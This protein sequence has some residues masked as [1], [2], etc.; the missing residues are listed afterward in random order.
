[1]RAGDSHIVAM[2]GSSGLRWVALTA[3]AALAAADFLAQYVMAATSL[4]SV[5]HLPQATVDFLS[6]SSAALYDTL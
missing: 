6:V 3:L 4:A 2:V 5:L 1:M